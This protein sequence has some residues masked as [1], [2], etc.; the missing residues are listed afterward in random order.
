MLSCTSLTVPKVSVKNCSVTMVTFPQVVLC[1]LHVLVETL[2]ISFSQELFFNG[3]FPIWL[4]L[5]VYKSSCNNLISCLYI[6]MMYQ[7]IFWL[8]PV[9]SDSS[10]VHI[11]QCCKRK[12]LARK[13]VFRIY[14]I[15][16]LSSWSLLAIYEKKMQASFC[17][18]SILV[19][20]I[21]SFALRSI[22]VHEHDEYM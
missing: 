17:L 16:G 12:S 6:L 15:Y 14:M 4:P 3:V 20:G 22:Y 2:A 13:S 8:V 19:P 21:C 9:S 11:V 5:Y 18:Q 1:W 10:N 7:C